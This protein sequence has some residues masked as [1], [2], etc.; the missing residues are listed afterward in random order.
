[1]K[2]LLIQSHKKN[3]EARNGL[4]NIEPNLLNRISG[5][6]SCKITI[7]IPVKGPQAEPKLDDDK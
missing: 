5:G 4:V 2:S 7:V 6:H 3:D 1:M